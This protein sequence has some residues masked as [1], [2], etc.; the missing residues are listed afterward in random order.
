MLLWIL[1]GAG[2]AAAGAFASVIIRFNA[3]RG[4]V[5]RAAAAIPDGELEAIYQ[6]VESAGPEPSSSYILA[7]T[8]LPAPDDTDS[9]E[10]PDEVGDVP[11]AGEQ[12]I[13]QVVGEEVTFR[14]APRDGQGTRL[15]GRRFRVV[16]VPQ[17]R[18]RADQARRIYSPARYIAASPALKSAL[19]NAFADDPQGLLGYLLAP[20]RDSHEFDD[21]F[22]ARIAATPAWIQN[23]QV[24]ACDRCRRRMRLIA[25]IPGG[26]ITSSPQ[27]EG[28]F[29][30]FAC[31]AH[32]DVTRTIAQRT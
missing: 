25:Q 8:H 7:R 2:L 10:I 15:G 1:A 29:Y 27:G 26:M 11:W 6:M 13:I 16:R 30:L 17:S 9:I 32:P 3:R 5:I 4:A 14:R 21:T 28:A 31:A 12:V 18:T 20:G 23:A 22:Q 19:G 24:P